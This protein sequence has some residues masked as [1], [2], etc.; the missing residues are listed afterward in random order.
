M[1]YPCDAKTPRSLTQMIKPQRRFVQSAHFNPHDRFHQARL[2]VFTCPFQRGANCDL[3]QSAT[4]EF[5]CQLHNKRKRNN[6]AFALDNH[7]HLYGFHEKLNTSGE[8]L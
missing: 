6:A 5:A 4:A 3:P 8:K 7:Y 1:A 2:A